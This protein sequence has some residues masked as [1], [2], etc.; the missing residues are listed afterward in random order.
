MTLNVDESPSP[1]PCRTRAGTGIVLG[2]AAIKI[3]RP[4][5][6]GSIGVLAGT[7]ENIDEVFHRPVYCCTGHRLI[8]LEADL[9]IAFMRLIRR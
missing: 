6:I 5:D 3:D 1:P 7:A 8:V 9:G 2:K 4:S